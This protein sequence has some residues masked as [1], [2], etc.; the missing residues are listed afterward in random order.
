MIFT[1]TQNRSLSA[2]MEILLAK[3]DRTQSY[4]YRRLMKQV[5]AINKQPFI[6]ALFKFNAGAERTLK[7]LMLAAHAIEKTWLYRFAAFVIC[8]CVKVVKQDGLVFTILLTTL[9]YVAG[10]YFIL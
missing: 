8:F 5:K 3:I 9:G 6:K 4:F 1:L 7:G 10:Y 2:V